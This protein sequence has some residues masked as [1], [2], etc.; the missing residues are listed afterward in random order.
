MKQIALFICLLVLATGCTRKVY[1]P[2][3]SAVSRTDTLYSAKVRVDSVIMRD[4]VAVFQKGDTVMITKYRDRYRVKELTDT[5]YQSAIDSVKV[6]VPYPVEKALTPWESFRLQSF[7]YLIFTSTIC[8]V[9]IFRKQL[10]K[11]FANC[12]RLR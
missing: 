2:V 7:W 12:F 5:V 1:V 10:I 6:S 9:F 11:V 3:E 8:I 4:S